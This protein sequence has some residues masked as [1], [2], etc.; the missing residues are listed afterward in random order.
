M[1]TQQNIKCQYCSDMYT[2]KIKKEKEKS[3]TLVICIVMVRRGKGKI[4]ALLKTKLKQLTIHR[5]EDHNHILTQNFLLLTLQIY[6][7]L[8]LYK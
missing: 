8:E 1:R 6:T 4:K 2:K 3:V 5:Y 7:L